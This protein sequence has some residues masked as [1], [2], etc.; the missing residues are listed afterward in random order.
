MF[1]WLKKKELPKVGE[2]WLR[3]DGSPWGVDGTDIEILDVKD[4][5]VRYKSQ[6]F[7]SDYRRNIKSF[8]YG[9]R[10]KEKGA[11]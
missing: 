9:H 3:S 2:I 5:W 8:L 7:S 4:G 10:K 6:S 1:K 11:N